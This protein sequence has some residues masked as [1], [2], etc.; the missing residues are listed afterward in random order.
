MQKIHKK[1]EMK[2]DENNLKV[3]TMPEVAEILRVTV[4]SVRKYIK[5]GRLKIINTG[6]AVRISQEQLNAFLRGE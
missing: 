1:K 4:E 3:Y 5:D 2:M 6:G